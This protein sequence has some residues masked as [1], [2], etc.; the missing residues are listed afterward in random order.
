LQESSS[1]ITA[2]PQ[3]SQSIN[4]DYVSGV[5]ETVT[6]DALNSHQGQLNVQQTGEPLTEP[7]VHPKQPSFINGWTIFAGL[8][9]VIGLVIMVKIIYDY[10]QEDE[11]HEQIEEPSATKTTKRKTATKKKTIKKKSAPNQRRKNTRNR[12]S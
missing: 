11:D 5:Q 6:D 7:P 3:A 4:G 1:P 8:F 2:N 10:L 12:K 9:L